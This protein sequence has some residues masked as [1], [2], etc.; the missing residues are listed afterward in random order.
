MLRRRRLLRLQRTP[1]S[2][3]WLLRSRAAP[4]V[5]SCLLPHL[6]RRQLYL[7]SLFFPATRST[8]RCSRPP[9]SLLSSKAALVLLLSSPTR[10]PARFRGLLRGFS[11]AAY[12]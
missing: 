9:S 7:P 5:L 2:P 4:R 10:P 11:K 8:T 1:T 3:S 6:F 12:S